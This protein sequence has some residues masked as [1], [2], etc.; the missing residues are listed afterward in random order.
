MLGDTLFDDILDALAESADTSRPIFDMLW[1][2]SSFL[3]MLQNSTPGL[4]W[5]P[6][7]VFGDSE[8]NLTSLAPTSYGTH[9]LEAESSI[10]HAM[11]GP[12]VKV[13]IEEALR[14]THPKLSGMCARRL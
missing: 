1:E 9:S 8:S 11:T 10:I 12:L 4:T 13:R 7:G 5:N 6:M 2:D 14:E 3:G